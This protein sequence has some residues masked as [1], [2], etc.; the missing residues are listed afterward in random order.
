M[1]FVNCWEVLIE[2]ELDILEGVDF[3]MVKFVLYY[4]DVIFIM[5][6]Y[7]E[8]FIVAYYVSGECVM[9]MAVC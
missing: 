9:F 3:F 5:K 2:G 1:N 8:V 4:M 7:F 6:Q